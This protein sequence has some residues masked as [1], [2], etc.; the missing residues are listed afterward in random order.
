M[1]LI[2]PS[3]GAEYDMDDSVIPPEGR[4]VRCSNCAHVWFVPKDGVEVQSPV[5]KSAVVTSPFAQTTTDQSKSHVDDDTAMP[6]NLTD[7][8]T[9][10][11]D[12]EIGSQ[13]HDTDENPPPQQ[14]NEDTL[15]TSQQL[16]EAPHTNSSEVAGVPSDT[17]ANAQVVRRP[18]DPAVLQILRAEA[19][20]ETN[21]RQ[22][23]A[24]IAPQKPNAD[25]TS[26]PAAQSPMANQNGTRA[27]SNTQSRRN[28]PTQTST[29]PIKRVVTHRKKTTTPPP[30]SSKRSPDKSARYRRGAQVGFFLILIV[31]MGG[32]WVY[33]DPERF[34]ALVSDAQPIINTF[35]DAVDTARFWIDDMAQTLANRTMG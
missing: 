3:C 19:K 18:I 10:P 16:D 32:V 28:P 6:Q 1:H 2:C 24:A 13:P 25:A 21:L 5:V 30:S 12:P 31:A 23:D 15:D 29:P 9:T 35:V 8:D 17:E 22:F 14:P 27:V 34:V 4:R 33:F 7:T 11:Q 20:R 26:Q